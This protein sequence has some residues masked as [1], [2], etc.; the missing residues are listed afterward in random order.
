[1]SLKNFFIIFI[2]FFSFSSF[3][4]F[5]S[6]TAVLARLNETI[7]LN[8]SNLDSFSGLNLKS[9]SWDFADDTTGSGLYVEHNYTYDGVYRVTATATDYNGKHYDANVTVI[10][11]GSVP[12]VSDSATYVAL[13]FVNIP[14]GIHSLTVEQKSDSNLSTS[15]F[16][17]IGKFFNI[18]SDM[19]SGS[20][21]SVLIFSYD[22]A[23]DDGIVDGT[24]V[25]ENSLDAYFYDGTSWVNITNSIK[26]TSGN[27][28]AASVDHFTQFALLSQTLPAVP[29]P[30]GGASNGGGGGGGGGGIVVSNGTVTSPPVKTPNQTST[31]CQPNWSCGDWS[32]CSGGFQIRDC[33]DLNNCGTNE[34]S[35]IQKC[36]NK[37]S[38][39]ASQTV[40][41]EPLGPSATY[42]II[43]VVAIAAIVFSV[44]FVIVKKGH[45]GPRRK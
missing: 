35:T 27:Y 17:S 21:N 24:S 4:A 43:A 45:K 12:F 5:A 1:M 3:A 39:N 18:E 9:V 44:I 37:E 32:A 7:P 25:N 2:V 11:G 22:D 41:K 33:K 40:S 16:V 34:P 8:A 31:Q 20:F 42:P 30:G 19:P 26:D 6:E 23:D 29:Q 28:I 14:A 36:S 15:G 13:Y 10:I 38:T